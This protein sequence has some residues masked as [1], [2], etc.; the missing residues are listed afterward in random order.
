VPTAQPPGTVHPIGDF[1]H[2]WYL[3]LLRERVFA[4]WSPP[5]EPFLGGR[6]AVALVAFRIDRAGRVDRLTLKERS[7]HARFDRSALA[8]V[9][10]LGQA[11][12]LPDQYPEEAL[13]VVI[14]FQNER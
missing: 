6:A 7:G 4:L 12:A 3:A 11:P 8:A 10:A 13:D 14:R 9:Q 2:A 5:S 1:P